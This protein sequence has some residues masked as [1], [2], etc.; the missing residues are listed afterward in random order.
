MNVLRLSIEKFVNRS[1]HLLVTNYV[2]LKDIQL[3]YDV[4]KLTRL[5]NELRDVTEAK[6]YAIA[7]NKR[8]K[9]NLAMYPKKGKITG[10]DILG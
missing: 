2:I 8:Y 10:Q 1:I 5:S 9:T 7:H 4:S 3:A 6:K